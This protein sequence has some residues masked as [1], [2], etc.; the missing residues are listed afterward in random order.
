MGRKPYRIEVTIPEKRSPQYYLVKDIRV[1]NKKTKVK[2]YIGSGKEMPSPGDIERFRI[3]YAWEL[4]LRAAKAAGKIGSEEYKTEYLSADQVNKLEEIRYLNHQYRESLTKSELEAYEE[5]FEMHYVSGTTAIE[6]NTL[7]LHET[8]N[9]YKNEIVPGGKSL[10]EIKE[11]ENFKQVKKFRDRQKGNVTVDFIKTLHA[12]IMKNIDD[13]AAGT[14][15]RTD[16]VV[17]T[18]CELLPCPSELIEDEIKDKID[19]YYQRVKA[20]YHPFEEAIMFHYFFEIT[21][22]FSDGNGRVGREILNFMLAKNKFPK[23][24]FPGKTRPQY[25]GALKQGNE[26]DYRGMVTGFT[27]LIIGQYEKA[28][29]DNLKKVVTTPEKT[30][31]RRITQ[32]I[33]E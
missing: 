29:K 3:L 31:Q 21:H 4:E 19:Y 17:I 5:Q 12:I 25:I 28:L 22:P 26:E 7:T 27:D 33:E 6:G 11:I 1:G 23:L 14:F 10:R 20:G 8:M 18:G 24:L 13:D 16:D 30:G 2:K 15:R 32:W 9:L